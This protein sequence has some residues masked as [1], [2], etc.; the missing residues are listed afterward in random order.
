VCDFFLRKTCEKG[1]ICSKYFVRLQICSWT[2][3]V[4]FPIPPNSSSYVGP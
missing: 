4:N 3:G 1:L 2:A